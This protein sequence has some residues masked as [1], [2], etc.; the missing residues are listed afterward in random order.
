MD[1]FCEALCDF[2]GDGRPRTFQ[3]LLKDTGFARSTLS[4]HLRHL[5]EGGLVTRR[6]VVMGS[7][8][9]P[10][11]TY[12]LIRPLVRSIRTGGVI[13][14]VAIKFQKLSHICRYEK[15]GFCKTVKKACS[16]ENCPQIIKKE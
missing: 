10:R 11:Y 3:E 2:L 13:D 6:Q 15:G 9:R 1:W 12:R 5:V 8:G 4:D 16:T 7:R 14:V